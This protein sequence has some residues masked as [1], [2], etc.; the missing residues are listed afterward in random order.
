M[1]VLAIG[2]LLLTISKPPTLKTVPVN[3]TP[4]IFEP[5]QPSPRAPTETTPEQPT[6]RAPEIT[7][8]PSGIPSESV[9]P[10]EINFWVNN[11]F[12]P[13]NT[14]FEGGRFIRIEDDDIKTFAGSFGPYGTDPTAHLTVQLCA[15]LTKGVGAQACEIIPIVYRDN[16][17]SFAK[18][19]QYDEYI[20]GSAAKDYSAFYFIHVGDTK[21]GESNHAIIRTVKSS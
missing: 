5:E 16:Y 14:D 21:V 11:I 17:V 6:P 20:G 4:I 19:Y 12:V 2:L 18:G 1:L 7:P 8:K 13:F 10:T 3:P 15:E 9:F